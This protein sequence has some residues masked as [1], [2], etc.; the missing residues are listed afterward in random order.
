MKLTAQIETGNLDGAIRALS[1]MAKALTDLR[2]SIW[3]ESNGKVIGSTPMEWPNDL[4]VDSS[5]GALKDHGFSFHLAG[6]N[7]TNS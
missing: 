4:A 5:D 6:T 7:N 1:A 2:A 3:K